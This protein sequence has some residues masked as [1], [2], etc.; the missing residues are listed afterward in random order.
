MKRLAKQ[1]QMQAVK[2]MAKD[3]VRMRK[4]RQFCKIKCELSSLSRSMDTMQANKQLMDSMKN[5]S[6][7]MPIINKQINLPEL[8]AIMRKI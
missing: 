2:Y 3:I 7:I 5:I 4:H 8:Q 6:K 1:G